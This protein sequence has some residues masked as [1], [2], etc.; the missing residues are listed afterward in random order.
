MG[1]RVIV[2]CFQSM[3]TGPRGSCQNT[4][5]SHDGRRHKQQ[6]RALEIGGTEEKEAGAGVV[7]FNSFGLFSKEFLRR[8]GIHLLGTTTTWF[9]LDIALLQ[10]EPLTE[11]H[12]QRRR[13][14]SF[15]EDDEHALEELFRIDRAHSSP[16][17]SQY[18]AT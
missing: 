10:P 3:G 18:R 11:G 6:W 14:D 12:L 16:S 7:G 17:A 9:L 13:M 4:V 2:T 15:G 8:H 5:V 1:L